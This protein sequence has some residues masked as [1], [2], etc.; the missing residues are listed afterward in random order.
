VQPTNFLRSYIFIP[1]VPIR[2]RRVLP[3]KLTG[4]PSSQVIPHILW[5][6]KVHYRIHKCPPP[7]RFQTQLHLVQAPTPHFLKIHLNITPHLR[8]V[9]PSGH[10]LSSLPTKTLYK[11][12]FSSVR[13]LC[14]AHLILLDLNTRTL[15]G[16]QY[17]LLT[18]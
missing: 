11:P 3:E 2:L 12:L 10:F 7:V 18:R 14:P 9:L 1:Y 4:F 6:P 15:L 8:L 5:N 16:E 13:A 17:R